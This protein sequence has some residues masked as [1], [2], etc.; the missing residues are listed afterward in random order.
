M[1]TKR[2]AQEIADRT[3]EII[4]YNVNVMDKDGVIIGSGDPKRVYE[5]HTGAV[6]AIK[7]QRDIEINEYD[8]EKMQGTKTG[9]NLPISF[10][11]EI[12]G[13]I[14]VTGPLE[15][16][17]G[18]GK[19]VKMAAELSL[20]QAFLTAEL[21]WDKR[22]KEELLRQ[23]LEGRVE[24]K[25]TYLKRAES[26]G[27]ILP[28][29][30]EVW[31]VYAR[32]VRTRAEEERLHNDLKMV[33]GSTH[34]MIRIDS[35]VHI[36]LVNQ[37]EINE[38]IYA[39]VQQ[40]A[41][42]YAMVVCVGN[43]ATQ[44][45]DI[46]VSYEQAYFTYMVTKGEEEKGL[47]FSR[48]C[49]LDTMLYRLGDTIEVREWQSLFSPIRSFEKNEELEATLHAFI[50][51]NGEIQKVASEL[52][53]HRNTVQYRLHK[54]KELTGKDPRDFKDLFELY[55]GMRLNQFEKE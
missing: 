35:G 12:V 54:I 32:N 47:R 40:F 10:H 14:G 1:L 21:Q 6:E 16:V 50:R 45:M 26:L 31:Y 22:H 5:V 34:E 19:L 7:K 18:Y 42:E 15:E 51:C 44:L 23:L 52:F 13:V 24:N 11:E 4:G 27:L 55:A 53:V 46:A 33:I 3:I 48:E 28:L 17:R 43:R 9:I 29:P 25:N 36:V 41:R 30:C 39:D 38:N 49:L 37:T 8:A 20:N 2:L